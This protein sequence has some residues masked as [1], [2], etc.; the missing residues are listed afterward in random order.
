MDMQH[1]YPLNDRKGEQRRR[2]REKKFIFLAALGF[3]ALTVLEVSLSELSSRLTLATSL[4]FFIIVNL[5]IILLG[6]LVFLVSLAV[7]PTIILF[8]ISAFYIHNSFGSW[9]N[10]QIKNSLKGGVVVSEAYY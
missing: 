3:T 5:N 10:S 6:L 1:N 7:I 4:L 2:K 8:T 9:F